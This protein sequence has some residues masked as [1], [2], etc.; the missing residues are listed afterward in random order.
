[1]RTIKQFITL[2]FLLLFSS[3]VFAQK[4]GMKLTLEPIYGFETRLVRYPPPEGYV[5]GATYGA[6]VIVGI[7][8]LSLEGEYTTF[9]NREEY[10]ALDTKVE[11]TAE[12]VSVGLRSTLPLGKFFALYL[13]AGGRASQGESIVTTSGVSETKP[14]PLVVSPYAGGGVQIALHSNFAL[15]GGATLIRNGEDKYD[16]Q[17]TL[18]VSARIGK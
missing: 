13:R 16:V 15:N 18:G 7:N 1:M 9:K 2:F 17:Y 3:G 12:R 8:I 4:G 14:D 6:R 11:D 5:T 10:P